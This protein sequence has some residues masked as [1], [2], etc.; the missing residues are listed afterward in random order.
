MNGKCPNFNVWAMWANH[1]LP[2]GPDW[3][4]EGNEA[5]TSNGDVQ[6]SVGN[7]PIGSP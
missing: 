7:E 4:G 3:P 6:P 5:G 2:I 1:K